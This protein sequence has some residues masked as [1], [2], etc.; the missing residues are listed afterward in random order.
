MQMAQLPNAQEMKSSS[1]RLAL[2]G[3]LTVE[4]TLTAMITFGNRKPNQSVETNRRPASPLKVDWQFESASWA[5][6]SLSAA[7]AHLCRWAETE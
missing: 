6:P 1:G 2:I 4:W 3:D 5:P 7:V